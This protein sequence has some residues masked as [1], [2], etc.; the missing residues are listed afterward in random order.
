MALQVHGGILAVMKVYLCFLLFCFLF[1]VK[2]IVIVMKSREF[3]ISGFGFSVELSICG[4]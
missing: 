2:F 1:L 3:A 4:C